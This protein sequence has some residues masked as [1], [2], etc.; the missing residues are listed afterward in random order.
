MRVFLS[1]LPAGLWQ[2]WNAYT[3]G[4][5]YARTAE[6]IHSNL[7]ETLVWLRVPGDVIFVIG[8]AALAFAILQIYGASVEE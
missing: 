1:L 6:F 3:H 2:T 8:A 4:H 5:W 7:M